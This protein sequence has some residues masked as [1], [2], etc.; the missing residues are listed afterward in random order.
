MRESK[1]SAKGSTAAGGASSL[2]MEDPVLRLVP[3]P[4]DSNPHGDV[5]GGWIMSQV[6]IAGGILASRRANGRVATVAVTSFQFKEPVFVGDVISIFGRVVR[7]GRTSIT[8][9]MSVYA[10]RNRL[11]V[12]FVKVTEATLV[13]VATDEHRRPRELPLMQA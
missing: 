3:M 12:N 5:F 8:I 2:P 7:T 4:A 10:E 9:D 1:D 11:N 13:F 6:D